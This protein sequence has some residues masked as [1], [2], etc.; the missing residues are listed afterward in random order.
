ME[1]WNLRHGMYTTPKGCY[2]R[3]L[4]LTLEGVLGLRLSSDIGYNRLRRRHRTG[5][6]ELGGFY[7]VKEPFDIHTVSRKL[8]EKA[9]VQRSDSEPNL[10]SRRMARPSHAMLLELDI[11][12]RRVVLDVNKL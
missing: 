12:T 9:T 4:K 1:A 3:V 11:I 5:A 8:S 7:T 2:F 10:V 6:Y